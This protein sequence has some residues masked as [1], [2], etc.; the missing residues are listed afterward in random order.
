MDRTG[1][2]AHTAEQGLDIR[3]PNTVTAE[4]AS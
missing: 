4:K 1:P 2:P 3:L